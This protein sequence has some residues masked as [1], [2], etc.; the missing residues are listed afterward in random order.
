MTMETTKRDRILIR[1][2]VAAMLLGAGVV[3]VFLL[4][5]LLAGAVTAA[6]VTTAIALGTEVTVQVPNRA[7][8]DSIAAP[9]VEAGRGPARSLAPAVQ[10]PAG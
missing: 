1:V 2:L 10:A 7:A 8:A 9:L 3:A 5:R 4:G 6:P